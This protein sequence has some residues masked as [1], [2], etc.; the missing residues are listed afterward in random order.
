[1]I[2]GCPALFANCAKWA[3]QQA[4]RGVSETSRSFY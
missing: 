1:V 3:G 4:T 2:S